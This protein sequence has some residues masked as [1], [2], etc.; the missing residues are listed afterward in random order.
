MQS[1][2]ARILIVDDQE[3]IC[4]MLELVL[5]GAGYASTSVNSG[6]DAIAS[7]VADPPDLILLDVSMPDLDGYAVATMIKSDPNTASIPIIMVSAQVGR[8][9]R[10]VGLDSGAEDY[11]TKPVDTTELI[12]KVRNLLRLRKRTVAAVES[13]Q[14]AQT[15]K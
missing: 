12:L 8:G 3:D 2:N 14:A 10:V 6:K 9:S 7:V 11:M 4:A 15:A 1:R 13:A 5:E